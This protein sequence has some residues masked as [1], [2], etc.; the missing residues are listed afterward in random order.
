VPPTDLHAYAARELRRRTHPDVLTQELISFGASASEA[1]EIIAAA[2]DDIEESRHIATQSRRSASRARRR[3][4]ILSGVAMLA[5]ALGVGIL[6]MLS[7]GG[8]MIVMWGLMLA[9]IARIAQGLHS[10]DD[11]FE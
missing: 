3:K 7:S 11:D 6:T 9:G 2:A 8:F 5:G 10:S 4:Y 1:Q